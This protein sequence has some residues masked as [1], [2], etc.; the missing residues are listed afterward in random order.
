MFVAGGVPDDHEAAEGRCRA[1]SRRTIGLPWDL[2]FGVADG[3]DQVRQRVRDIAQHGVDL[4]KI[5]ATGAF[6]AH[7]SD[8]HAVEFTYDEIRAAVEEAAH[9]GLQAWPRT[10]TRPRAS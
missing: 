8:P 5:I 4:I 10:P 6:L 2:R 1:I 9:K 3:A 7:G